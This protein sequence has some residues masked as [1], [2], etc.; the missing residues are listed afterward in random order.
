MKRG[1][2]LIELLAV[3]TIVLVV[4]VVALPTVIPALS[5]R[6]VGESA[7]LLQGA[8]AGARDSAIKNNALAG[9][10]LLPDPAFA[11]TRLS[12]GQLDPSY[13]L[14]AGSWIPIEAPPSY[15]EGLVSIYPTTAY[16]GTV[17]LQGTTALVLEESAGKWIQPLPGT[18]YVF[19]P[20]SP[21]SWSW[22]IRVGD[23]VQMN[24]SG[25][26]YTVVG[27]D[28]AG[29]GANPDRFINWGAPGTVSPLSRKVVSPD[30]QSVTVNPDFLLLVNGVDDNGDGWIDSGFD[31]VDNNLDGI[32]DNLGPI[33]VP[34]ATGYG[35]WEP[36][37]WLGAAANGM[38]NASYTVT[39]RPAP[40]TN[41]RAVQLPSNVVV[42]LTT[43]GST[44]ERSR[45]PVDPVTG[46][47]DVCVR[48]GGQ[49]VGTSVYST[50]SSVGLDGAFYHFWL[51]ERA[52][53]GA[54]V[55]TV[56]PTLSTPTGNSWLV[57]L[58]ART[59]N[60]S[61]TDNPGVLA[62]PFAAAQQ[63]AR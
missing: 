42:D 36:E 55:G 16:D 2:T 39:R 51:A 34:P 20:N 56:A 7:R 18:P 30:G 38:V 44:R 11:L 17:I 52:D 22:N 21:T 33:P 27:P 40:A 41:A 53:V 32:I 54:P 26:W 57:T 24:E 37:A 9:I 15:G 4:S 29:A 43:W 48:P 25:K 35:E 62:N 1:F 61:G 58:F 47:V 12:N 10:R 59:G 63:G 60:V 5:H 31:G 13:P 23:R 28:S 3:I 49:V 14:V 8:L 46:T 19:L 45:L 6:Q 50:Q